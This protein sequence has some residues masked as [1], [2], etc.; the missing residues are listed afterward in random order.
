M[1]WAAVMRTR[2]AFLGALVTCLG[3][4]A[5]PAAAAAATRCVG[6][7]GSGCDA[8]YSAIGDD[9]EAGSAVNAAA[10]G[11]TIRIGPGSYPDEVT[12]AKELH[13]AGAG[14]G[15]LDSF[16]AASQT[17]IVGPSG[18]GGKPA[19]VLNG[20]GSVASIQAVGGNATS[21]EVA[22]NGLVLR[23][24]GAGGALDYSVS[25]VV[26]IGGTG[27]YGSTALFVWDFGTGRALNATVSGG[28]VGNAGFG[29]GAVIGSPG[30]SSSLTRV[31][32]R[33]P[34]GNGVEG[35]AGTLRIVR[36]RV[37]ARTALLVAGDASNAQVD[38]INSVFMTP[39][40]IGAEPA[41]YVVTLGAGN[42][43]LM[44]RG[45]TFLARGSGAS[46]GIRLLK[47]TMYSGALSADLRNTIARTESIDPQANDLVADSGGTITADFSNF[48]TRHNANGGTSP[49]PLSASNVVGDPKFT[50]P[51]GEDLTLQAGSP[52]IDRGDPAIVTPGELDAAGNPRSLDGNGDC[53]ARPDIGAFERPDACPPGGPLPNATPRVSGFSMSNTVFAPKGGPSAAARRKPKRGTT[54]RYTLSEAARVTIT[55]ERTLPGRRARVRGRTRCLKPT[56][57]NRRARKCSRYRRSGALS[58]QEQPG[59]QSTPFSGRLRGKALR[60]GRYRARIV[61]LDS[62]GARSSERRLAFRVVR[63]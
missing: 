21:L 13:F 49:S 60:P 24:L 53:A 37:V 43:S 26:A 23:A 33:A 14:A 61:A 27:G 1:P 59:S 55:I 58:G 19:I 11:D 36:S 42:S 52:L 15:T 44:A 54:F 63:P 45:S 56:R 9:A 10:A 35:R 38:A 50:N 8:V 41:G 3:L 31:T 2:R 51:A 5:L 30:G 18:T 20:G 12:T 57:R 4:A 28:A 48:T 6:T 25:D 40:G 22:G 29:T 7:S 39:A 62:L 16:D 47:S 32:V 17:R 46:A 34:L